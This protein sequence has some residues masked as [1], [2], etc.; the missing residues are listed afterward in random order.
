MI[1]P[2]STENTP[3]RTAA[4]RLARL[5]TEILAP[6][7][8]VLGLPLAIAWQATHSVGATLLWGPVVGV[9]GSII[10][11]IVI[12]RGAKN[13]R[14]E[15]HHVTNREGRVVPFIACTSSLAAGIAILVGGGSPR[16]MIVLAG[17]MFA[18]LVV[19]VLI[20]FGLKF[21]L[22]M[23]AGVAAGAVLILMAAYGPWLVLLSVAVAL[24]AW[25]RVRLQDHTTAQVLVGSLVGVVA[26]GLPFWW[27]AG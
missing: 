9:T 2:S 12:V 20:T 18:T 16:D 3:T 15:G 7:V 8:W 17:A 23:H 25:S 4:D 11:M 24:V 6:W 10:P 13:G 27:L 22:S 19:S 26:G 21:K 14:W 5:T 1:T